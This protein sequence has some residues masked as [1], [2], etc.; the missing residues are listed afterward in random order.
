MS[1]ECHLK[2]LKAPPQTLQAEG[3]ARAAVIKGARW[4]VAQWGVCSMLAKAK[5]N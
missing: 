1:G 5:L 3:G 4:A 2:N